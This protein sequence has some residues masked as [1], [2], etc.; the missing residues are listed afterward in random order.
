KLDNS[1]S[2]HCLRHGAATNM[3]KMGIRLTT[4]VEIIGW[5]G[6]AMLQRYLDTDVLEVE[7]VLGAGSLMEQ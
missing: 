1:L 7:K 3:I 5:T 2:F 4:I 6:T